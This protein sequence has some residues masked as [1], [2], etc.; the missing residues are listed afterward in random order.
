MRG[1][2]M[3]SDTEQI[4]L[5]HF[6]KFPSAPPP[7]ENGDYCPPLPPHPI[8]TLTSEANRRASKQCFSYAALTSSAHV[9]LPL[10]DFQ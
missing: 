5:G 9:Y 10:T 2:C 7:F 3:A 1:L 4:C 8:P 6:S